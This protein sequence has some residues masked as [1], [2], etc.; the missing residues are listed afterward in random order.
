MIAFATLTA[1]LALAASPPP[2]AALV[3]MQVESPTE[4]DAAPLL[5]ESLRHAF[6]PRMAIITCK[7]A[8]QD[9]T[10][11]KK[12]LEG[13][14]IKSSAD[15]PKKVSLLTNFAK[16]DCEI[17]EEGALWAAW[18]T[19]YVD[20]R[21]GRREVSLRMRNLRDKESTPTFASLAEPAD[22][23]LSWSELVERCVRRYFEEEDLA[24]IRIAPTARVRIRD[25]LALHAQLSVSSPQDTDSRDLGLH[26]KLYQCDEQAGC[27]HFRAAVEEYINCRRANRTRSS[28]D[29]TL[30]PLCVNPLETY[31]RV[32]LQVLADRTLPW[33]HWTEE[34]STAVA[35]D[36][37][38]EYVLVASSRGDVVGAERLTVETRENIVAVFLGAAWLPEFDWFGM[39]SYHRVFA[40]LPHGLVLAVGGELGVRLGR[41]RSPPPP[42][43][44][45]GLL[46][47]S[48]LARQYF[49]TEIYGESWIAPAGLL[50]E[51]NDP[52]THDP[53][54]YLLF[55]GSLLGVA[56]VYHPHWTPGFTLRIAAMGVT[57][58][59]APGYSEI[60]GPLGGVTFEF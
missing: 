43:G 46:S 40:Q 1:V 44:A 49:T 25:P 33:I 3:F 54:G 58:T 4:K 36:L 59:L 22:T 19:A 5:E 57:K 16:Y 13:R 45:R 37:P 47:P 26:W 10:A 17:P 35:V 12:V 28:A 23:H 14:D 21:N 11:L 56:V 42:F 20:A 9:E 18:L 2:K 53:G 6:S 29:P 48:L 15:A 32:A 31:D 8:I 38:G 41:A 51:F 60:Y 27:D 30:T 55:L 24:E 52:E 50:Y 7:E 39:G 34:P